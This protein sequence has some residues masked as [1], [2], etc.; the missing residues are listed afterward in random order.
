MAIDNKHVRQP[1]FSSVNDSNIKKFIIDKINDNI[2]K[3]GTVFHFNTDIK[4]VDSIEDLPESAS[5]ATIIMVGNEDALE[6]DEYFYA[7]NGKWELYPIII[8]M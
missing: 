7:P 1:E 8:T 3:L 5:I 6:Y 2:T 4:R